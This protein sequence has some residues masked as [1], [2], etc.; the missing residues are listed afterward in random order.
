M[1]SSNF[2]VADRGEWGAGI[3]EHAS[4]LYGVGASATLVMQVARYWG[5]EVAVIT[6]SAAEIARAEAAGAIGRAPTTT[7]HRCWTRPS[8]SRR[9]V[10]S[11][12]AALQSVGRGGIVAINAIPPRPGSAVQLRRLVVGALLA[13]WPTSRRPTCVSSSI[14]CPRQGCARFTR[15]SRLTEAKHR[16]LARLDA[17]DVQELL[18]ASALISPAGSQTVGT[19][20]SDARCRRVGDDHRNSGATTWTCKWKMV[21]PAA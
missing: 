11:S 17:G 14:W 5:C 7:R 4:S 16:A 20:R 9:S 15:N 2:P 10:T 6:R 12:C 21:C 1:V 3:V 19:R 8:P 18:R 13:R